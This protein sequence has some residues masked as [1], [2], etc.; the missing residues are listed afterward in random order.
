MHS[1]GLA[2]ASRAQTLA[3]V[4]AAYG[5]GVGIS[6]GCRKPLRTRGSLMGELLLGCFSSPT[7]A[8]LE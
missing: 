3:L 1:L 7:I 4:Y 2:L 8:L 5:P 6:V